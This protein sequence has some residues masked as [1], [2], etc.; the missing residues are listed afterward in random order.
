[1]AK[2][3]DTPNCDSDIDSQDNTVT[4]RICFNKQYALTENIDPS[5]DVWKSGELDENSLNMEDL[6]N[7][8]PLTFR[9][10]KLFKRLFADTNQW[11]WTVY[12][13]HATEA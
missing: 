13:Y 1:M 4:L 8:I 2:L 11:Q 6:R 12:E 10:K 7:E 9:A 3:L 5:Q